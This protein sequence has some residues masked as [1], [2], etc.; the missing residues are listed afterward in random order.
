MDLYFMFLAGAE[1]PLL[2]AFGK[3]IEI[4]VDMKRNVASAIAMPDEG[5]ASFA[6]TDVSL[7]QLRTHRLLK[8][9]PPPR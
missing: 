9:D 1:N 8:G 5:Q 2:K 3:T 6:A 4:P 7:N